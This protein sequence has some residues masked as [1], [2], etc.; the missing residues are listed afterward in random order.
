MENDEIVVG[1][2]AGGAVLAARLSEDPARRVLLVEA[3][4]DYPAV[5]DLPDDLRDPWISLA[6]HDWG[7]TAAYR[8]G[9]D[10]PY[11]RGKTIGGSTAVNAAAAMRGAPADFADWVTQGNQEWGYDAVLPY[12][13]KLETESGDDVDQAVHG[14]CGPLWIERARH[15]SWEPIGR[16]FCGALAAMG[17]DELDDHNA[18][19]NRGVGPISHNV[20]EGMRI[21]AATAYLTGARERPNLTVRAGCVA[22][23]VVV[24]G[25]RARGVEVLTRGHREVI[26]GRRVSL[27]AGAIGSPA[28]LMRS[29]IGPAAALR[30]LGIDV[31]IDAPGVGQN[32]TDHCAVFITAPAAGAVRQNPAEYFEFYLRDGAAYLALLTL[33]NERALGVFYGDPGSAPVVAIAPGLGRP[34]SRGTV[35]LASADPAAAPRIS[36]NFLSDP[37]DQ[38]ALMD[39]VRLAWQVM[40]SPEFEPMIGR[41]LPPVP[42][43]INDDAALLAW[44]QDTCGTGFHPVGTCRM[45]PDGDAEAVV[46]Q[47]GRVRGVNALR[48][49]DAS[50]MPDIVSAPVNLTCIM[51]GERIAEWLRAR[52]D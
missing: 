30:E 39:A 26:A 34:R 49:A 16:A 41:P 11:P 31:V 29:G 22:D 48:I 4:P 42:D 21:S 19:S 32:L 37:E 24:A 13:A 51:I 35:E 12:Y 23:R 28:I 25:G 2:G 10:L 14:V 17:Y 38:K 7:Y 27:A 18:G 36:L 20:R 5:A 46:D 33:F 1:S 47:Y 15:A 50:I 40:H 45:G 8:P 52:D 44:M 9:R 43:I 3:G 6:D